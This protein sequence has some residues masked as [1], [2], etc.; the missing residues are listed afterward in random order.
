MRRAFPLWGYATQDGLDDA[1]LVC[2]TVEDLRALLIPAGR[3]HAR[4]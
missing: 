4:A 2:E 3:A 1:D